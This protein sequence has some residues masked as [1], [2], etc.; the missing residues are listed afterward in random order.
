MPGSTYIKAKKAHHTSTSPSHL[1]YTPAPNAAPNPPTLRPSLP[2]HLPYTPAP[3]APTPQSQPTYPTPPNPPTLH[4]ASLEMLP[5]E[6]SPPI[7]Q[8]T[9]PTAGSLQQS[10][11]SLPGSPT[12]YPFRDSTQDASPK[13]KAPTPATSA[14]EPTHPRPDLPTLY[15]PRPRQVETTPKY[16]RGNP[17][18]SSNSSTTPVTSP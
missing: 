2:S 10:I 5:A 4:L 15:P 3:S 12:L 16:R 18:K 14:K 13:A 8:P 11:P 6:T 17:S 7:S 1:P 9:Y